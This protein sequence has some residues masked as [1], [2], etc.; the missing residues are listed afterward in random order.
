MS[1]TTEP[2]TQPIEEPAADTNTE[3]P[4]SEDTQPAQEKRQ[5]RTPNAEAASY[6]HQLRESQAREEQ[7]SQR[8]AKAQDT[9]LHQ[10]IQ[11]TRLGDFNNIT[12][13]H[14]DDLQRFT[15][16]ST[17]DYFT[18]EGLDTQQLQ[19]DLERLCTE[20]PELFSRHTAPDHSQ[21]MGIPSELMQ[22][23]WSDAFRR[24]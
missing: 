6:R 5:R 19:A 7:L 13:K 17:A 23:S 20:R 16:K 22:G 2:T 12:L 8:L 14:A 9:I 24:R 1:D 15:G 11:A 10:T 18:E 4:Q 3:Q 21:G